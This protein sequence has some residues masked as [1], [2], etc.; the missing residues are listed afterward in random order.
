MCL[1]FERD[2]RH[3]ADWYADA[4]VRTVESVLSLVA[5]RETE[6]LDYLAGA[7]DETLGAS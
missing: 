7:T 4:A 6:L 1:A 2:D 5:W 3:D